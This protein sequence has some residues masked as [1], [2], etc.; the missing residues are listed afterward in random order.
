MRHAPGG[1]KIGVTLVGVQLAAQQR[2][3]ARLARAVGADQADALARVDGRVGAFKE[4]L[5]APDQRK[6]GKADQ[7]ASRS[8]RRRSCS[9]R[10][11]L[12]RRIDL[13][14]ISTSSSSPMNSTAYSSVSAIGGVRSIASSLPEARILVSCLVLIG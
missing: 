6:I 2:E 13:G 4:R 7:A 14:V 8:A 5:D 11:R 10:K 1:R 3:Q 9:L 12:R